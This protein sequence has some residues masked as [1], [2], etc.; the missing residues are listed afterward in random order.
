MRVKKD[1]T[2]DASKPD[3]QDPTDGGPRLELEEFRIPAFVV[4]E[5]LQLVAVNGSFCQLVGKEPEEVVGRPCHSL[6]R[7][8]NCPCFRPDE[9]ETAKAFLGLANVGEVSM[10]RE[11]VIPRAP[12]SETR[13]ALVFLVPSTGSAGDL[14]QFFQAQKLASL[15]VL[16]A[17]VAHELRNPLAIISTSLY[18]LADVLRGRDQVVEKHLRIMQEEVESA[19]RIIEDLLNFARPSM[20]TACQLDLNQVVNQ[21]LQLVDKE[22]LRSDIEVRTNLR[23]LPMVIT[24]LDALK[25]AFLNIITNAMQAMPNGAKLIIESELV[26]QDGT[27]MACLRFRDTGIGMSPEELAHALDP[28]YTTK[29]GGTGLGLSITYANLRRIGGDLRISSTRG[30]GTTVEV[31]IPAG[32]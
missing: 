8:G 20:D 23:P 5:S 28:F 2:S 15:G 29:L 18:F 9:P 10:L 1:G 3:G 30:R 32:G 25:H 19:R 22:L 26:D 6:L 7:T 24:S 13:G 11:V 16:A 17:G 27:P 31:R 12:E 14:A 21:V 4:D